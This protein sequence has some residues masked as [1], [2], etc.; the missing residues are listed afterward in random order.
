[1]KEINGFSLAFDFDKL[2]KKS[3]LIEMDGPLLSL[4]QNEQ[5]DS[6]LFYWL[7]ADAQ[8]NRWMLLR[9]QANSLLQYLRHEIT[10]R[11]VIL[12]APDAIVWISDLNAD[13]RWVHTQC[14]AV[15]DVPEC[16]LPDEESFFEFDRR[17]ELKQQIATDTYE[18]SVPVC[19]R[20]FFEEFVQKMGWKA[21][22][23]SLMQKFSQHV[24]AL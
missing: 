13:K 16:Y 20:G 9:V 19:D 3:D 8:Q 10:L 15:A 5:G 23:A 11:E 17:D 18:L 2:K 6:Y 24:A 22:H 7:D 21:R 12:Q 1:M 14:V 4:Y